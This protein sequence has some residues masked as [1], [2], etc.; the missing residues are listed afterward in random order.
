MNLALTDEVLVQQTLA[1]RGTGG[2]S[3]E[4]RPSG[5]RPAFRDNRTGTVYPSRFADGRPAPIHV[6]G[7][8]PDELVLARD[9]GGRV[10]AVDIAVV[11][12]FVR[13]GRFYTRDEAARA[14]TAGDWS[15][16]A[17]GSASMSG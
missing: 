14:S 17:S 2:T 11:S 4:C 7:G 9:P 8:L 10:L 16:G 12:G 15:Q 13:D 6:L 3:A 1:F 5:L